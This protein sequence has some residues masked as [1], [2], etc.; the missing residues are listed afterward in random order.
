MNQDEDLIS[1][2]YQPHQSQLAS[3]G[4]TSSSEVEDDFGGA[5]F[6][7]DNEGADRAEEL[8]NLKVEHINE[9]LLSTATKGQLE[10]AMR[11]KIS[12]F[13]SSYNQNQN[14]RQKSFMNN[15]LELSKKMETS[16]ALLGLTSKENS[17]ANNVRSGVLKSARDNAVDNI[18]TKID[19]A[20]ASTG[21]K[22]ERINNEI[23]NIKEKTGTWENGSWV[24]GT[25]ESRTTAIH[26]RTLALKDMGAGQTKDSMEFELAATKEQLYD[27]WIVGSL[28]MFET[29]MRTGP[30]GPGQKDC[31]DS[32]GH[33]INGSCQYI[34]TE[35]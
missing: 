30:K 16:K 3:L 12:Q 19:S 4:Y 22:R 14:Q 23:D 18:T 25:E 28:D 9:N 1:L 20:M 15:Q 11:E 31:T 10:L 7:Y 29:L 17:G 21:F 26:D 35:D 27:D 5:F 6:E 8:K 13:E 32:G 33:W 24:T 34:E 2:W